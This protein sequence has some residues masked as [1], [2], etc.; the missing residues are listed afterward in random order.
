MHDTTSMLTDYLNAWREEGIDLDGI[1]SGFLGS[2]EQVGAILR[3]YE[4]YPKPCV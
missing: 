3:L 2:A 1:Y 4:E